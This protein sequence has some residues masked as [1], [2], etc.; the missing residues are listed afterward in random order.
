MLKRIIIYVSDH[1]YGHAAR[2]IA[3]VRNLLKTGRFEIIIKNYNAFD[4]LKS[5]L[6]NVCVENVQTDVGPIF[7]W[8]SYKVDI[9]QTADDFS[10]WIKNDKIWISKETDSFNSIKFIG[11]YYGQKA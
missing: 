1:G 10:K 8:N 5:S 9:K 11:G 3:L 7:D 2:T 6:P 4:F